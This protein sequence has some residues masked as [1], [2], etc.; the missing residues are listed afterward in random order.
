MIVNTS[1]VSEHIISRQ[2]SRELKTTV[3]A[4]LHRPN[5]HRS[6]SV[7]SGKWA[8]CSILVYSLAPPENQIVSYTWF[9][10]SRAWEWLSCFFPNTG[11]RS[12]IRNTGAQGDICQIKFAFLLVEYK[13]NI[14]VTI[15][16][17]AR[18]TV[19]DR[20]LYHRWVFV[21]L[22]KGSD[23]L[24]QCSLR[25]DCGRDDCFDRVY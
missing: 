23:A 20:R 2:G 14:Y 3:I 24:K 10:E 15:T 22:Y 7:S 4:L 25:L 19:T 13:L 18:R 11:Y 17:D 8:L 1:K 5:S 6:L 9:P 21:N 16:T 12:L